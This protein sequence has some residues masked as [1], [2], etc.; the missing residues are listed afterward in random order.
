MDNIIQNTNW[1]LPT[2]VISNGAVTGNPWS[3]PN[4]LLLVD[5]DVAESNPNETASDIIVGNYNVNLPQNAVITGI[6]LQVIGY[7]GGQTTP[8]ITLT[9]TAVDNTTGTDIFYPYITPFTGFTPDLAT[10]ILGGPNYLFATSWTPD[11]INNFKL[12]LLANGDIYIDS[13]LLQVFYYI[14]SEPIPPTPTPGVCV[15]CSSPV[16]LPVMYL[17]LP[18]KANDRYAYLQNMNYA[19]GTPFSYSDIGAC[20]GSIF[21]VFDPTLVNTGNSNFAENTVVNSNVFTPLPDGTIQIDFGDI[22]FSRGLQFHTPYAPDSNLRSDH[23]AQ[24]EVII[25]DSA[26]Y[27]GTL[28]RTCQIGQLVSA[29]I[30]V[31]ENGSLILKP[32]VKFN[33][34]GAGQATTADLF[35][36]TQ[37]N[38]NIPGLGGTTPPLIVASTSGTSFGTKV[39]S[40]AIAPVLPV[41]GLQRGAVVNISTQQSVAVVSATVGGVSCTQ[42]VTS[43]DVTHDLRNEQWLC[44][45]PPLGDQPV[46]VTLSAPAWLTFGAEALA[47]IDTATPVGHTTSAAGT[48]NNP[49][50]TFSTEYDY[51][52]VIDGLTTG[53]TPI[54]FTVGPGQ[55]LNWMQNANTVTRQGASSVQA[56]GLEPDAVTM[57]YSMTQNTPW[58]YT[59]LEIKGITSAVPPSAGVASVTGLQVNN[60][61]PANPIILPKLCVD[62]ADDVADYLDPKLN[63][64]SSDTSVTITKTITNPGANEILDYNFQIPAVP[65]TTAA[66]TGETIHQIGHGFSDG[67]VLKSS[68]TDDEFALAQA[69]TAADAQSIGIVTN[70]P[71][72]DHF[73]ITTEGFATLPSLPGGAAAGNILFLDAS[74]PG[75]LTLTEPGAGDVSK[76]VA[77]V[78]DASTKLIYIHNYRGI[79]NPTGYTASGD[80]AYN[81]PSVIPSGGSGAFTVNAD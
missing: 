27:L 66:S 55:G 36:P 51:S 50:L 20:G 28:L 16:Q 22:S 17:A 43:T 59:A 58:V 29:P 10:Y 81:L 15:D 18:F 37:V 53:M 32:T 1:L 14:P 61:D 62:A 56:A 49:S 23:D 3:N 52:I 13:V 39:T 63:L 35:D 45:N 46:V 26:P 68:G 11:M 70:V 54:L 73:L 24:A 25:S 21:F 80:E 44:V 72:V 19:N 67:E 34:T 30:Q 4:N 78:I 42:E 9:P 8:P 38:I 2:T 6:Q 41:S 7:R 5:G 60:T 65:V 69:N 79:I 12:Q 33:F 75:A 47:Q 40:L 57:Q 64:H 48:S 71:D 76:P 77:V 74:T 31:Y